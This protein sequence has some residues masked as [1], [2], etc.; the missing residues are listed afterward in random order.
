MVANI[1]VPSRKRNFPSLTFPRP[2]FTPSEFSMPGLFPVSIMIKKCLFNANL[3]DG[4][5]R[6]SK[7]FS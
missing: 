1:F 2:D 5:S 3:I 4:V 7:I 6:D